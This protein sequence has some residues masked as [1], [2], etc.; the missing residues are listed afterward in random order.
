[1][2]KVPDAW[3]MKAH[4]LALPQQCLLAHG[5]GLALRLPE[6]YWKVDKV[7]LAGMGG[8]AIAGDL[9]AGLAAE[10][11][12]PVLVYR[13]YGPPPFHD[14][15]TLAVFCSY[16]GNTE[17]TLSSFM[18]SL[19]S[20]SRKL[21]ITSG[22]RLGE[23]AKREGIPVFSIDYKAP[24][25]A[26]AGYSF[27]GLLGVL[28]S[29]GLLKDRSAQVAEMAAVLEKMA[30]ALGMEKQNSALALARRLSRRLAVAYGTGLLQGVARRWKTQLNENAKC[31]AFFDT[32]PEAHHN[33]VVGYPFPA[34]VRARTLVLLFSSPLLSPRHRLRLEI[35]RE[36]LQREGVA[37]E[38]VTGEGE[39]ALSQMMSLLYLGD[40]VSYYLAGLHGV[41]PSPVPTIDLL[42]ERLAQH[43]LE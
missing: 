9:L 6:G 26:A 40:W 13:D 25:R 12:L 37:Y 38:E 33:S 29:L 16:S 10:E 28:E 32:L 24:P 4:L 11:G 20:P 22:G 18:A 39:T 17:E 3:G 21:V 14:Q 35:T 30:L 27:L 8:S 7:V 41:D 15:R 34:G 43:P 42:K 5:K 31:W 2:V 36:L 1:M 23:L 19:K